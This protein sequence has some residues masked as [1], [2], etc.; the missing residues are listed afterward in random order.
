M[1]S[2]EPLPAGRVNSVSQN[3]LQSDFLAAAG[4]HANGEHLSHARRACRRSAIGSWSAARRSGEWTARLSGE[5]GAAGAEAFRHRYALKMLLPERQCDAVAQRHARPRSP[6]R[7]PKCDIQHLIAVLEAHL[8]RVPQFLVMPWLEGA[9]LEV[10]CGVTADARSARGAVDRAAN[11]RGACRSRSRR[12]AAWRHQAEQY[13]RLSATVM[14]TLL[15][16]GF[17]R[18][19]DEK[20]ERPRL[21]G[22]QRPL[23]GAGTRDFRRPSGHPQRHLQS[24]RRA[25]SVVAGRLPLEGDTLEELVAAHKRTA[26]LPSSPRGA[27]RAA[28]RGRS[29]AADVGQ[30]PAAAAAI[31]G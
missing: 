28:A 13:P 1:E 31:A 16:L 21:A 22:R 12:L 11:G 26:P 20:I 7:R 29:R 19:R 23:P 18:H 24:W 2:L 15:D 4:P 9:S 10:A 25:L 6:R 14:S 8:S 30:R 17:A 27:A 3:V 5:T